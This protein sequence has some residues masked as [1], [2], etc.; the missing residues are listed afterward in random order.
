MITEWVKEVARTPVL[1]KLTPNITDIRMPARAAKRGGADALSAINT[2]NS[3][4]GIDLDTFTPAPQRRRQLL[5]RRLLRPGRETDRAQH[6]A[7][8]RCPTREVASARSPASAASPAGGMPP[9]SSCS[10][11]ARCRSAP[12]PCTTATASSKT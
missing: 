7:A 8:D 4:T 1:V 10:A 6:G 12:P 3:I 2:I 5:A 9:S 11:A